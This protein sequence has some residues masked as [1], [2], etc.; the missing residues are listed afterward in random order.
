MQRME[1]QTEFLGKKVKVDLSMPLGSGDIWFISVDNYHQGRLYFRDGQWGAWLNDR[2]VL[3][4]DDILA[5]G[6][7]IDARAYL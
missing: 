6:E 3:T 2:S 4:S 5:M 1:F 7:R